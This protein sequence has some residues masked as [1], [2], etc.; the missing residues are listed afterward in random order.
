[1]SR[2]T[3][4]GADFGRLWAASSVSTIGDG[5]TFA[6]G[7][8]L[9]ATLTRDPLLLG[10]VGASSY[11]PWLLVGLLSG[12]MVDRLDRRRLMWTVDLARG[13]VL[14]LLAAAVL[15]GWASIPLLAGG[16]FLLGVG[17]TLFDSAAQ[18]AIPDLVGRDGD[19][20]SRAN[21]RLVGTQTVGAQFLGPPVGGL[22]FGLG[23]WV[24]YAT[25]AASFL[26]SSALVARIRG[27]HPVR[28]EVPRSLRVEIAEGLRW[29]YRHRL[30]RGFALQAAVA[31]LVLTAGEVVLVLVAQERLGLG[32][33]GYGLLITGLAGGA[34]AGSVLTARLG[35]L[36]GDGPMFLLSLGVQAAGGLLVAVTRTPLVAAVGLALVGFG[37]AIGNVLVQSLRQAL[38]PPQLLGRVVS[39]YRLVGLGTIPLGALA[40]GLVGRVDLRLPYVL[41]AAVMLLAAVHAARLLRGGAIEQARAEAAA[42]LAG[43]AGAARGSTA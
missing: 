9:A 28:R 34:V 4:L 30:L 1:M 23:P 32:N 19:Q 25:D 5:I 40:G 29:L 8:L 20:L 26:G 33:V 10:V 22:L 14:A 7:P 12:A 38:T 6:A 15:A 21:G 24:P 39:A 37:V 43:T 31:N 27:R 3:G 36:L 42:A 16:A 18:A 2:T 35:R 17:Q 11:L 41:G 13:V